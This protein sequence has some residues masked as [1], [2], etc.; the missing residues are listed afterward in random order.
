MIKQLVGK[1][2]RTIPPFVRVRL[3]RATQKKF[4]VSVG[5]VVTNEKNQVL[6]L[7]HVFR[8]GSG[9]GI[10][11]GFIEHNEQIDE[12]IK[13]ELMEE[14]GLELENVKIHDTHTRGRHIEFLVRATGKGEAEVKSIEIRSLGW[15]DLNELPEKMSKAQKE[16][17]REVLSKEQK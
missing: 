13:R 1:I 11:G 9:W 6:L 3:I 16:I 8:P 14:V 7:D 12:A 4:T 17:I 10:P 5:A 2:W 15:F